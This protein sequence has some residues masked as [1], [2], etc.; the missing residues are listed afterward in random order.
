MIV[1]NHACWEGK[2]RDGKSN[3]K[4]GGEGGI[5]GGKK[6]HIL[7]PAHTSPHHLPLLNCD[8]CALCPTHT[9]PIA[10]PHSPF[11]TCANSACAIP[12]SHCPSHALPTT[13][14]YLSQLISIP[15]VRYL[16][17]MKFLTHSKASPDIFHN[18]PPLSQMP[19]LIHIAPLTYPSPSHTPCQ[20]FTHFPIHTH[21]A[22]LAKL[23]P[24]SSV[25]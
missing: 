12:D 10:Q 24:S 2:Q 9:I 22:S 11:P 14:M 1:P 17:H 5:G 16:I 25:K 21:L 19:S 20:P 6:P 13:V 23:W 8:P 4:E 18:P 15:P 7:L 3:R